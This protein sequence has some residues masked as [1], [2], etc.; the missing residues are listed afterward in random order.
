MTGKD[1]INKLDELGITIPAFAWDN[2]DKQE[3]KQHVGEY[4]QVYRKGG[5]DQGSEY[6]IVWHFIDHDVYIR[7]EG[8]YQS[9]SGTDWSDSEFKIVRPQEKTIIVYE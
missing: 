6:V 7:V 4:K 1:I 3:L 5:E 2:Y 8:Y 9:Y